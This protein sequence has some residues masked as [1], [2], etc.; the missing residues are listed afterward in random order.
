MTAPPIQK[1]Q[2]P[3]LYVIA[4]RA[5]PD[6]AI[7]WSIEHP[8]K[9]TGLPRLRLAMTWFSMAGP[10]CLGRAIVATWSAGWCSAQRI[11]NP[12]IA[13]GNHTIIQVPPALQKNP[14]FPEKRGISYQNSSYLYA[15][16]K[17]ATGRAVLLDCR[18]AKP[19][20]HEFSRR[21]SRLSQTPAA[22]S[23][24]CSLPA[25]TLWL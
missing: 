10:F 17:L 19:I 5:K 24:L 4:R 14:P 16:R 15:E 9:S 11:R 22:G 13:G 18:Q 1:D 20:R 8:G 12:M 2:P 7:P 6:V 23:L 3:N 21:G 25:A